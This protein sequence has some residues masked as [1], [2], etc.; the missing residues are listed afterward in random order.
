MT[1]GSIQVRASLLVAI[2]LGCVS[3]GYAAPEKLSG[4]FELLSDLKS[5]M[6]FTT[7]ASSSSPDTSLAQPLIVHGNV[8]QLGRVHVVLDTQKLF[9]GEVGER[10]LALQGVTTV[11][12]KSR[13]LTSAIVEPQQDGSYKLLL[14]FMDKGNVRY[15]V[16]GPF[17]LYRVRTRIVQENG[18]WIHTKLRRVRGSKYKTN[19]NL[20]GTSASAIS[21]SESHND[22]TTNSYNVV[23]M[24]IEG[25]SEYAARVGNVGTALTEMMNL[26]DTWYKRDLGVSFDVT[27]VSE[28]QS[29]SSQVTYVELNEPPYGYYP[30]HSEMRE[31]RDP[32]TR[33]QFI[34]FLVTGKVPLQDSEG[35]AG[36]VPG[37]GTICESKEYS[38]GF[39]VHYQYDGDETFNIETTAHEVGHLFGAEHDDASTGGVAYIMNSGTKSVSSFVDEFSDQSKT[40]VA[41]HVESHSSC[42]TQGEGSGTGGGG[43]S[44][45][46]GDNIGGGGDSEEGEL[47]VSVRKKK[48]KVLISA[49]YSNGSKGSFLPFDIECGDD[50]GN[51]SEYVTSGT[52]N[53]KGKKAVRYSPRQ[54]PPYC[55]AIVYD[56]FYENTLGESQVVRIGK[57][58]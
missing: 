3:Q 11:R 25:D 4:N 21:S 32:E 9:R 58:S 17:R 50:E 35:L 8:Y 22:V 45:G 20:C 41:A 55:K 16:R 28:V 54:V 27:I 13:I 56:E 48:K 31:K 40:Q 37:L 2:F 34:H 51:I 7:E 18:K 29:Y 1:L 49:Q 23:S 47:F 24:I 44:G 30:L 5:S 57:R 36:V 6:H 19:P 42:L 46:G 39:T 10:L 53:R 12:G 52:L 38:I 15:R 14:D 43:D 33:E 26:V